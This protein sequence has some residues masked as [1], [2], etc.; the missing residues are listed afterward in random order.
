MR[1]LD[2]AHDLL[3]LRS[4]NEF[5]LLFLVGAERIRDVPERVAKQ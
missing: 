4:L 3:H 2:A 1:P 5:V